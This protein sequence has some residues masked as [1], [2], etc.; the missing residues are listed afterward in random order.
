LA[1]IPDRAFGG[2][3]QL[4]DAGVGVAIRGQANDSLVGLDGVLSTA[5]TAVGEAGRYTRLIEHTFQDLVG[6]PVEAQGVVIGE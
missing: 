2:A 4:G 5:Q 3:Y 6:Q 1:A